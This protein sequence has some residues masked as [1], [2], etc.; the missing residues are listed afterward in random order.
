LVEKPL[1]LAFLTGGP[2]EPDAFPDVYSRFDTLGTTTVP[3][4]SRTTKNICRREVLQFVQ[5]VL[6]LLRSHSSIVFR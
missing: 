3:S 2:L 6:K 4:D 1:L 5:Q